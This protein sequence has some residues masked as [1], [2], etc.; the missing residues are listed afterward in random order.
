MWKSAE[1][2]YGVLSWESF[3]FFGEKKKK[4]AE[5]IPLP[6]FLPLTTNYVKAKTVAAILQL[7][8]KC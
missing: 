4:M 8:E 6:I 2:G 3:Y 1:L 7:W 5:A